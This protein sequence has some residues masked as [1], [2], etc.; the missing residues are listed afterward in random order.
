MVHEVNFGGYGV[1][2]PALVTAPSGF[3]PRCAYPHPIATD[4]GS[5][6][7][8]IHRRW[9]VRLQ[10]PTSEKVRALPSAL[11]LV[12]ACVHVPSVIPTC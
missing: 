1:L 11:E 9:R 2:Q 10:R 4:R 3:D 7:F 8:T 12:P 5:I 6:F